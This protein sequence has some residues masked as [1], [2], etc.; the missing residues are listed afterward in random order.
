MRA[1]GTFHAKFH[2][3]CFDET[4]KTLHI[5][6]A[7]TALNAASPDASNWWL[8][9]DAD[10]FPD[11]NTGKSIAETIST[12]SSDVRAVGGYLCEHLPTHA[13]YYIN[14][15]HPIDFMPVARMHG[16]KIW[17][18]PLLRHDKGTPDIFS[19]SGS[20]RYISEGVNIRESDEK[21][22]IHHFT[23]RRPDVTK[24]RLEAMVLPN[25]Q[26]KRR[27]DLLDQ[28]AKW[29]NQ[30][31]SFYHNRLEHLVALYAKNAL[32]NLSETVLC[33]DYVRVVRWY[34]AHTLTF[35]D[36]HTSAYDEHIWRGTHHYF[37]GDYSS[38][39][40]CF[41]HALSLADDHIHKD[42]LRYKISS[43]LNILDKDTLCHM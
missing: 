12:F 2:S 7:A 20:H 23:H 6:Q 37:L 21:L 24:R 18:F 43:C 41:Q 14:R 19:G 38:S 9:L 25:M 42:L 33:Y 32:L 15:T 27:V 5:N 4:L 36:A 29:N 11:F 39:F 13:P 40:T 28:R 31:R 3:D 8:Y 34:D 26:G 16:E 22:L 30:V 17:K 1:G 35:E 10:E